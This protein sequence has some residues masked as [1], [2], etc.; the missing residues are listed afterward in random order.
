LG[1]I[2]S[3]PLA[4]A[5]KLIK[6][7]DERY[8]GESQWRLQYISQTYLINVPANNSNRLCNG[9]TNSPCHIQKKRKVGYDSYNELGC[10]DADQPSLWLVE[11][12]ILRHL[13]RHF[14]IQAYHFGSAISTPFSSAAPGGM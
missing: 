9:K 2:T 4:Q 13:Q 5:V 1:L 11:G 8:L 6:A 3:G 10:I 7:N 12:T 14:E